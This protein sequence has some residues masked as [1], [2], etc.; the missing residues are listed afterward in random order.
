MKTFG[1]KIPRPIK[2]KYER[3]TNII[4]AAEKEK[5]KRV[6]KNRRRNKLARESRRNS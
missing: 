1:G 6:A 5:K 3:K 2:N 4:A